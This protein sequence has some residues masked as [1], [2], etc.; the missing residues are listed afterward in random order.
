MRN[1][2]LCF[3]SISF[4]AGNIAIIQVSQVAITALVLD[5][6]LSFDMYCHKVMS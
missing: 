3:K 6:K 4:P 2:S 5:H 1:D